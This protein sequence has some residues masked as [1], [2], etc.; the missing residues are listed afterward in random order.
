MKGHNDL[1][2]TKVVDPWVFK[3]VAEISQRSTTNQNLS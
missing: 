1:A 3:F 2:I